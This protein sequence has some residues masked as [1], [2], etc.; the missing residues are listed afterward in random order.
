MVEHR[1]YLYRVGGFTAM[2][3]P[4]DPQDLRSQADF[5]RFNTQTQTWEALPSLPEARS[6]HD[7]AVVGDTLYVVGGW[8]LQGRS[9][10]SKWQDTALA[11]NLGNETYA[12]RTIA[13]P[14][15]KRRAL[16]LAELDG[17]LYC[18]GGMQEKGGQTTAVAIYDS[19]KDAW[20]EGPALIGGGMEG[21]GASA[22][23]CQGA[24]YVTTMSGSVQRLAR[25]GTDW[26]YLGQLAHPRFFHRVLPWR[27]EKL[28][29][30]GGGSM[31]AGKVLEL[32]ILA[33]FD[34]ETTAN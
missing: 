29:V 24:L 3:K 15:F 34:V 27:N 7:A 31:T 11:M 18:V 6:S 14:P 26:E 25:D 8:N 33:G 23:T 9:S 13:P 4:G 5:A 30:V 19:A 10:E 28:V 22:F 1:G 17:R 20:S 21:F 2:N 16:A 32:E 12:W